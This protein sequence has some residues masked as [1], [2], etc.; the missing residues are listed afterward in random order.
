[1]SFDL[2]IPTHGDAVAIAIEQATSVV[3]VGANGSNKTRL[4][5]Y[6]ETAVGEQPLLR[7][8][9]S[10]RQIEYVGDICN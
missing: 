6:I 8:Q 10:A 9:S 5:F 3:F 4:A 2:T 1:M 7:Y